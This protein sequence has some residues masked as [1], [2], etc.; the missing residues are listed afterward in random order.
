MIPP[1]SGTIEQRFLHCAAYMLG[2][3]LRV[4]GGDVQCETPKGSLEFSLLGMYDFEGEMKL[5]A[6]EARRK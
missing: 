6:A 2:C 3:R 4:M 1:A 5:I